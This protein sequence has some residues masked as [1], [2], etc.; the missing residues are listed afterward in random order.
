MKNLRIIKTV[1]L[2]AKLDKA[3]NTN[4]IKRVGIITFL[5]PIV[6]AKNPQKY[7]LD[8][9]PIKTIPLKTPLSCVVSCKSHATGIIKLIPTASSTLVDKIIPHKTISK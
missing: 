1:K 2:V 9:N 3:V 7:I 6:S 5:L 4:D 8:I